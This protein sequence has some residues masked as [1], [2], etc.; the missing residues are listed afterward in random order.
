MPMEHLAAE[1]NGYWFD[2]SE[3][4]LA[5]ECAEQ[6]TKYLETAETK[7]KKKK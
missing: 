2:P 1:R 5:Q 7:K 3:L 6:F 4:D